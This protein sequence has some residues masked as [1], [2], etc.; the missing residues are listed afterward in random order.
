MIQT[1]IVLRGDFDARWV[2][3]SF[4]WAQAFVGVPLIFTH[5]STSYNGSHDAGVTIRMKTTNATCYYWEYEI[6]GADQG[7]LKIQFLG[8]GRWK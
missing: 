3:K 2:E 7:N 5:T 6:G 8:I 4:N 1:Y